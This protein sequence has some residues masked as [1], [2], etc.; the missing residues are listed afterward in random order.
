MSDTP[1]PQGIENLKDEN[2][3]TPLTLALQAELQTI[4]ARPLNVRNLVEL[5]EKAALARDMLIAGKNPGPI[6]KRR[7]RGNINSGDLGVFDAGEDYA[8][9][10]GYD[11]PLAPSSTAETFGANMIREALS[12]Y[13]HMQ[14]EAKKP[15]AT[16]VLIAIQTAKNMGLTELAAKLEADVLASFGAESHPALPAL[17]APSTVGAVFQHPGQNGAGVGQTE[18]V[19]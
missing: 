15:S 5:Q 19:Q 16:E 11:I 2:E 1:T 14:A 13:A 10:V 7:R 9:A 3:Q 18:V 12:T 17:P 6:R 4:A 8:A